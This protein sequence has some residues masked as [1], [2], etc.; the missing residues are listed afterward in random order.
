[1]VTFINARTYYIF[2]FFLRVC[3][4][5]SILF[6][7]LFF[8]FSKSRVKYTTESNVPRTINVAICRFARNF[9][10]DY[11]QLKFDFDV[12][13]SAILVNAE[14]CSWLESSWKRSIHRGWKLELRGAR[15]GECVNVER[16][17][18]RGK[19]LLRA[20][21][22]RL[23]AEKERERWRSLNRLC[24]D[25]TESK[26]CR[27]SGTNPLAPPTHD[28]RSR[29]VLHCSPSLFFCQGRART[30]ER[31]SIDRSIDRCARYTRAIVKRQVIF[32]YTLIL[33]SIIN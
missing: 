10:I 14:W 23:V 17:V 15:V 30:I 33:I 1:M 11:F 20:L 28:P 31:G 4:V 29:R 13:W 9:V 24:N 19:T 16:R 21:R 6:L 5:A 25:R 26:S 22:A 27:W 7:F 32:V 2:L 8:S 12:T 3:I 18:V